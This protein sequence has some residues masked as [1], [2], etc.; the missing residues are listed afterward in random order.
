MR[1]SAQTR[2]G[3]IELSEQMPNSI[4]KPT[5][6]PSVNQEAFRVFYCRTNRPLWAYLL[7]VSGRRDVADDLLQESY[8]RFLAA[9]L[10]EMDGAES[11]N[12]FFELR[13]IFC[14]IGG[15]A[16]KAQPLSAQPINPMKTTPKRERMCAGLLSS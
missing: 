3:S 14:V 4:A 15:V 1:I 8:C 11:R 10:P 12:I 6:R 16:G 9:A 7:R 5:D 2:A 13:Q